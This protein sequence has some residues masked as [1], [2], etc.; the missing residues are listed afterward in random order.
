MLQ[1]EFAQPGNNKPIDG[2]SKQE[3][4][5]IGVNHKFPFE[6]FIKI[7]IDK[8][9][10][11]HNPFVSAK[12]KKEVLTSSKVSSGTK[13][14]NFPQYKPVG[15]DKHNSAGLIRWKNKSHTNN[16]L[17]RP[18]KQ[19]REYETQSPY[20]EEQDGVKGTVEYSKNADLFSKFPPSLPTL[21]PES[22]PSTQQSIPPPT[23]EKL[24]PTYIV[25]TT[26]TTKRPP[27][28]YY[29]RRVE[30]LHR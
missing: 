17:H 1:Q 14:N 25:T 21:G 13:H 29:I 3:D 28:S 6:P 11:K 22:T 10:Q 16:R 8:N 26:T 19:E 12:E 20:L 27:P 5:E 4:I 9:I 24:P 7:D 23:T 2:Y 15:L 30:T 18:F